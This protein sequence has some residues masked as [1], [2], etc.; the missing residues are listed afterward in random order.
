MKILFLTTQLPYPPVSG[1]VIKTWNL[2]RHWSS[3]G[4]KVIC[5]LKPGEEDQVDEFLSKVPQIDHFMVPF[6]RKRTAFNLL[7]SVLILVSLV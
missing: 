6:E 1:G 2:V 7:K 5:A 3:S 4:L